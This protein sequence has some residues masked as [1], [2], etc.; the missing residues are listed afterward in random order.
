MKRKLNIY[1][2]I[3]LVII[4]VIILVILYFIFE[5]NDESR[6]LFTKAKQDCE[7]L[8]QCIIKYN[9][10]EKNIVKDYYMKELKEKY[11]TSG[12]M[13]KDPWGVFYKHDVNKHIVFSSGPNGIDFDDDDIVL[14]Y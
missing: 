10:S 14:K 4:I 6:W 5:R 11:F 8:S 12:F 9:Q 3:L 1:A 7:I 13:L 2:K